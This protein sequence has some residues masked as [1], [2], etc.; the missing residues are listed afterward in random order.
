MAPVTS[1]AHP[2]GWFPRGRRALLGGKAPIVAAVSVFVAVVVAGL[3]LRAPTPRAQLVVVPI[4]PPAAAEVEPA[5]PK[6]AALPA[7]PPAPDAGSPTAPPVMPPTVQAP[8]ALPPAPDP[9]ITENTP[10]GPLPVIAGDGRQAWMV[11]A[12]PFDRS[13][14]RPRI[15]LIISGLGLSKISTQNAIRNLPPEVTLSFMPYHTIAESM[16][17][18]RHAGHETVLD[19]P[20]EP[21]DYPRQDPGPAALL[22]SLD[23]SQNLDRLHWMMGR[24]AGYIGMMTYM[25]SRFAATPDQLR[26]VLLELRARGLAFVDARAAADGAAM[27]LAAEV[28]LPRGLVDRLL[29]T[30]ESRAGIEQQLSQLE[31]LARH[32]GSAIGVGTGY[33]A[34]IQ[35]VAS[36]SAQ[37]ADRGIALAP[38]SAVLVP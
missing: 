5:P 15:A 24:G 9:A 18:A 21:L 20:M 11:Y 26:P 23:S 33:P 38:L 16:Q 31:T 8:I 22:V 14:K 17:E 6:P 28:K 12:R 13:D 35:A 25:G 30:D 36:W 4:P 7:S 2:T 3:W 37:L 1:Y 19:L 34:T 27:R 32:N 29:E 10:N